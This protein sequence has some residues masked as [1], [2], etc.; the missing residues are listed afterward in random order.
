MGEAMGVFF[1]GLAYG[2]TICSLTCLPC[3]GTYLMGCGNG[4]RDGIIASLRRFKDDAKEVSSGFECG[5][6]LENYGSIKIGDY[7][8]TYEIVEVKRVLE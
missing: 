6:G 4:F 8:E 5:I 7:L 2:A 3:L 1:L